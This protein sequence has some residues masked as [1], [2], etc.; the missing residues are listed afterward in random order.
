MAFSAWLNSKHFHYRGVILRDFSPEGSGAHRP[1]G[2]RANGVSASRKILHGLKAVQD[3]A[4]RRGDKSQT[5]PLPYS[6]SIPSLS[7][8]TV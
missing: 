2:A 4:Y 8:G 1:I 3:D 7:R 5:E 6:R